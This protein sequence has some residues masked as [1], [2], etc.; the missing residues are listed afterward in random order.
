MQ[1]RRLVNYISRKSPGSSCRAF[2]ELAVA[3]AAF[4]PGTAIK[5]VPDQ[6]MAQRAVT[7]VAGDFVCV[8]I[9]DKYFRRL[10]DRMIHS[11]YFP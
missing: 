9:D 1:H 4:N 8:V 6:R 5:A 3:I 7:A 2:D 11:H 10:C